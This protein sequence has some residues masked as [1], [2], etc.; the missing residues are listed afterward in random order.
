VTPLVKLALALAPLG[1]QNAA[2]EFFFYIF[3]SISI[4]M[5]ASQLTRLLARSAPI[6]LKA[7]NLH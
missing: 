2:V 3:I 5:Q 4:F 6:R 7:W 1:Q